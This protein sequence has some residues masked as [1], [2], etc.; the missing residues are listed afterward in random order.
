M[1]I[2]FF[3]FTK[4]TGNTPQKISATNTSTIETS[5]FSPSRKTAFIIHGYTSTG[6]HG[7][8]V[9]MCLLL[10]NVENINCIAVDWEEG[11]KCTYFIAASNS[12]VLGAEVAYLVNTFTKMYK[13]CPSEVH[14]IGHSLGA[15]TAGEAGRRL[16]GAGQK[17]PGIGRIT[18][19]DPAAFC[20]QGMPIM[21]RLD[22]SDAEFVDII[23]SNGGQS[24]A[25]GLGMQ[26]ATGDLDFYPNGG[27]T[28][29]GC[30]DLILEKKEDELETFLQVTRGI[31]TCHHSRSHQ[32]FK[33][34]ILC[35]DGF[36]SYPCESFESF[37]EGKCF[38][39]P[40]EG[41]PMMGYYADRFHDKLKK[42]NPKYFLITGPVEPFCSW[43]YNVSVKLSGTT[44]GDINIVFSG[45]EGNA[46]K[47]QIA[48]G[49]LQHGR[50]YSKLI[51]TE[52]NPA[53][54]AR[55]A[56][57]WHKR[58]LTLLWTKLGAV[59]VNLIRGQDGHE[60]LFCG[61]GRVTFGVPQTLTPC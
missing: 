16:R 38:P 9:E 15:H 7:W 14:L 56:F 24:L 13:Y 6:R 54:A 52:I 19:L 55:V 45:K 22:P 5:Y 57:L 8:V 28:M 50:I 4:E 29:P 48:S 43:R 49:H 25:I 33:Y 3:L 10:A 32:Y 53:N 41:C 42:D 60:T 35:P 18:G 39:C 17:F 37:K 30:N 61:K 51:D 20:F 11:A 59:K 44:R 2:A 40:K 36:V 1:K 12:R 46:K 26:N 23:H 21:V 58:F 27:T 47:Y 34:S 31:G